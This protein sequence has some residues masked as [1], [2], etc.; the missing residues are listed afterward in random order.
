MPTSDTCTIQDCE[1]DVRTRGWCN[2][3][4]E[5]KRINGEIQPLP[6]KTLWER[7]WE[8]VDASGDCWVWVGAR[9]D[10]G[11]GHI[12]LEKREDGSS[13]TGLAHRV[14]W[15]LLVGEIPEGLDLDHLCRNRACVKPDHL[16]PVTRSINLRRGH[17][18]GRREGPYGAA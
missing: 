5:R 9:K 6:R 18:G 12:F 15:E 17:V 14:S 2:T 16:E 11:Y 1:R 10:N 13:K 4:Y 8:K 7:F 3:H